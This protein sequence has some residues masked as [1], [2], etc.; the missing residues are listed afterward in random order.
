VLD[1]VLEQTKD[2]KYEVLQSNLSQADEDSLRAAIGA[3]T[4]GA[5]TGGASDSS[6][7]VSAMLDTTT[8]EVGEVD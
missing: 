8:G 3:T 1:K 6:P 4:G 2:L 7:L 5:T